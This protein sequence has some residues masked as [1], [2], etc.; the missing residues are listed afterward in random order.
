MAFI[1]IAHKRSECIGCGLCVETAPDYWFMN[2]DGEACLHT[3]LRT[4]NNFEY[5]EGYSHD[6]DLLDAAAKGCP[7]NVIRINSF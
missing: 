1:P 5:G 7:V 3:I 4:Q 2:A 6:R